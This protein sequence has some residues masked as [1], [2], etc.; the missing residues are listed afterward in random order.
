M[1]GIYIN[2]IGNVVVKFIVFGGWGGGG[3]WNG[4]EVVKRGNYWIE[5]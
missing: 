1:I 4:E 5:I 3:D 2:W